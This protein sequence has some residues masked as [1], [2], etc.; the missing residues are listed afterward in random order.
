MGSNLLSFHPKLGKTHATLSQTQH[1]AALDRHWDRLL[2]G[3]LEKIIS[4]L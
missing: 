4:L 2:I 1:L 3:F